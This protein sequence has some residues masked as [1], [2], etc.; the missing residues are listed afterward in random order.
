[1]QAQEHFTDDE[2]SDSESDQDNSS[3]SHQATEGADDLD[4]ILNAMSSGDLSTNPAPDID[5][6]LI[7]DIIRSFET[8]SPVQPVA[9]PLPA[10]STPSA[11]PTTEQLPFHPPRRSGNPF[12]DDDH[13]PLRSA[14]R[15]ENV[16]FTRTGTTVSFANEAQVFEDSITHR[17]VDRPITRAVSADPERETTLDEEPE[18]ATSASVV[19]RQTTSRSRNARTI[20][21]AADPEEHVELPASLAGIVELVKTEHISARTL[22]LACALIKSIKQ[23]LEGANTASVP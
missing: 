22:G 3:P 6:D 14:P 17:S 2:N 18:S 19:F 21:F 10:D 15:R 16:F 9:P 12:A 4:V 13:I 23:D 11:A 7:E 20:S 8:D 1:M 5:E